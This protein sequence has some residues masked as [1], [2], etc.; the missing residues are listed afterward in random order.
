[1]ARR[2]FELSE[3]QYARVLEACAP[4]A[5]IMV[6]GTMP[7]TSQTRANRVWAALGVE[8]GFEPM[9]VLPINGCGP[10]FFTAEEVERE[11]TVVPY[12][13]WIEVEVRLLRQGHGEDSSGTPGSGHAVEA[14]RTVRLEENDARSL[15]E[16]NAPPVNPELVTVKQ[17]I[18]EVL[19]EDDMVDMRA[20]WERA[21]EKLTAEKMRAALEVLE[22]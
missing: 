16:P 10:R 12:Y 7:E 9:T 15:L 18:R 3:Q 1:M 14:S 11:E 6:G 19:D 20:R 4:L 21:T 8:M 2:E 5:A 22:R 13:G 17:A